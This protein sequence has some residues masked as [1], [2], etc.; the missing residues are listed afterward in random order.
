MGVDNLAALEIH[1]TPAEVPDGVG[2]RV[3]VGAS[4]LH[5]HR[6]TTSSGAPPG[7]QGPDAGGVTQIRPFRRLPQ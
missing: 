5:R 7:W 3:W 2:I 4:N 1:R 6:T